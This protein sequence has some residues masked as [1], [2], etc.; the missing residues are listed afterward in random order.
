MAS[1]CV[2][3]DMQVYSLSVNDQAGNRFSSNHVCGPDIL[4]VD[5]SIEASVIIQTRRQGFTCVGQFCESCLLK[6]LGSPN[7]NTENKSP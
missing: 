6:R 4:P 2:C 1:N 3:G 7:Y 5:T